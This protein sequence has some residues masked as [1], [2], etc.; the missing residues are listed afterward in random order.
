MFYYNFNI[1]YIF[2]KCSFSFI[3]VIYIKKYN[4][5]LININLILKKMISFK[6]IFK[7][8]IELIK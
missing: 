5:T 1:R 7:D 8:S 2:I 6:F 3:D 4:V